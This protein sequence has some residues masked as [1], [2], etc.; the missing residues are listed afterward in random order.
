MYLAVLTMRQ[1]S[2]EC[3]LQNVSLWIRSEVAFSNLHPLIYQ[4]MLYLPLDDNAYLTSS[5]KKK[6]QIKNAPK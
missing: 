4:A 5:T 3:L 6:A 1:H 2:L